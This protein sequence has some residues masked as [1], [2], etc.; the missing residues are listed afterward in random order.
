MIEQARRKNI[1]DGLCV[2]DLVE[3]LE[4]EQARADLIVAA[5]AFVYFPDL[6]PLCRAAARVLEP[7]GLFAFT[8]EMHEGAGVVLGEKLR[9]GA[10]ARPRAHRA[11]KRG[12]LGAELCPLFATDGGRGAG[13]RVGSGGGTPVESVNEI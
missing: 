9:Y 11:R 10:F 8:A 2:G 12:S 5:D 6:G 4:R 7:G 13:S 3:A 1:Y